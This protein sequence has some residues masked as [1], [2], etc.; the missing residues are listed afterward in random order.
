MSRIFPK[1]WCDPDVFR[2]MQVEGPLVLR[3]FDYGSQTSQTDVKDV[4]KP[5]LF[6]IA[7]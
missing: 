3:L 7:R 6:I 5:I 1:I 2:H 4:L